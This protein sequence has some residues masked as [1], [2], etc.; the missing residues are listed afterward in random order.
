M[1]AGCCRHILTF[2]QKPLHLICGVQSASVLAD[3]LV[4]DLVLARN[5]RQHHVGTVMPTAFAV[6]DARATITF[7]TP[8]HSTADYS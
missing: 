2:L 1:V 7:D 4:D 6:A 3:E 5:E 8:S